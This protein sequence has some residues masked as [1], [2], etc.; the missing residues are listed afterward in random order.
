MRDGWEWK[1]GV[2]GH[3]RMRVGRGI[4]VGLPQ[5]PRQR[6][7]EEWMCMVEVGYTEHRGFRHSGRRILVSPCLQQQVVLFNV[8]NFFFTLAWV[9]SGLLLISPS[10][11]ASEM[12]HLLIAVSIL[13]YFLGMVLLHPLLSCT[14]LIFDL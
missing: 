9:Y 2:W 11:I 1:A 7:W 12:W 8:F 3:R 4:C 6:Q 13:I 14:I 10:L 5:G